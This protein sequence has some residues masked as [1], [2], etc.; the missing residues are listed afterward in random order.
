MHKVVRGRVGE[1]KNSP[2]KLQ[3]NMQTE[4]NER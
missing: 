1:D 2:T 3:Q 4:K